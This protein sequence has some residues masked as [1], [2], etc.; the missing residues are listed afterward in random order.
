MDSSTSSCHGAI[1]SLVYS[2]LVIVM[3]IVIVIVIVMVKVMVKVINIDSRDSRGG[4]S[5]CYG[6][7]YQ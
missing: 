2:C 4:N 1:L 5:Y 6:N 7:S 3:V